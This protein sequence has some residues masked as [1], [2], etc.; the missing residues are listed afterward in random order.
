M[1]SR[2]SKFSM[3]SSKILWRIFAT[4]GAVR[5]LSNETAALET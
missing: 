1:A 3:S 4:L 5:V 2:Y